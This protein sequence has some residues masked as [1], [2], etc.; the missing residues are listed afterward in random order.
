MRAKNVHVYW[1]V[2]IIQITNFDSSQKRKKKIFICL[3][4][5]QVLQTYWTPVITVVRYYIKNSVL[6]RQFLL[7]YR[8]LPTLWEQKF[9]NHKYLFAV[10]IN[11]I[12]TNLSIIQLLPPVGNQIKE[13]NL[14]LLVV[15][16]DKLCM[17]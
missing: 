9:R 3:G 11:Q 15:L 12:G 16:T 4:N 10:Y 1:T 5:K 2:S 7:Y 14:R 6:S 17:L 8:Q 13:E